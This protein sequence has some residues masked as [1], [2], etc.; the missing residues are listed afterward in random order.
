MYLP[1]V[2]AIKGIIA[3]FDDLV[4]REQEFVLKTGDVLSVEQLKELE[5]ITIESIKKICETEL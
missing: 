3:G 5:T 1:K 4:K 2:S